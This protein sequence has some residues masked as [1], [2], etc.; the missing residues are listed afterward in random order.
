MPLRTKMSTA[1]QFQKDGTPATMHSP[2]MGTR[3]GLVLDVFQYRDRFGRFG[4]AVMTFFDVEP[5]RFALGD[6]SLKPIESKE[7]AGSIKRMVLPALE[8][9]RKAGGEI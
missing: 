8:G 2:I 7:T 5:A 9:Y 3:H 4:P 1:R 6:T